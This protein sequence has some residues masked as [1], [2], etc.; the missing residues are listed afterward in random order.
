MLRVLLSI[1]AIGFSS[2]WA[3]PEDKKDVPKELLPFQGKW[4]VKELTG[5][6]SIFPKEKW[7]IFSFVGDKLFVSIP[8]SDRIE[9]STITVA[10]DKT[11]SE[12]DAKP[13]GKF[14]KIAKVIYKFEK[15]TIVLC[16]ALQGMGAERPKV[17]KAEKPYALFVLVKAKEK[18]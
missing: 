14:E 9:T 7:P 13:E 12:M 1:L 4:E 10:P 16:F 6:D 18:K 15:D 11:P 2:A 5:A 3:I 8:S 17:F